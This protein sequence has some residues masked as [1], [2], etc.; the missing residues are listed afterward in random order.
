MGLLV[1]SASDAYRTSL[2][3]KG[4]KASPGGGGR[5]RRAGLLPDSAWVT[6]RLDAETGLIDGPDDRVARPADRDEP[7]RARD[8]VC[9]ELTEVVRELDRR[10]LDRVELDRRELD[11]VE[12]DRVPDRDPDRV[13]DRER[14]LEEEEGMLLWTKGA[15]NSYSGH[16]LASG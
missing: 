4:S 14:P 9:P 6:L 3:R 16:Q 7:A 8:E 1:D 10:E 5:G 13:R 15:R 12:L 2:S 11:R